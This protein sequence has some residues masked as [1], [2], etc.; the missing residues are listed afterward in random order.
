VVSERDPEAEL[1]ALT[2]RE[3]YDLIVLGSNLRPRSGRA[4][5]GYRVEYIL[6]NA[7]CPVVVL[8]ST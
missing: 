4:F 1:V 8:A 6:Q 3:D 7:D 5:F 2:Q